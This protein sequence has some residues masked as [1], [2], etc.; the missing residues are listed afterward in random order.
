MKI[1]IFI[2]SFNDQKELAKIIT[3]LFDLNDTYTIYVVDDGSIP[4]IYLNLDKAF[5]FRIPFN[6]GIGAAMSIALHIS[7]SNNFDFMVRVD[8]DGQHP[9]QNVKKILDKMILEND[10]LCI[11]QRLNNES[12][13]T[14]RD[15][16]GTLVKKHINFLSN[17]ITGNQIND[18]STG[19]FAMNRFAIKEISQFDYARYPEV[20]LFL[21]AHHLG[22]KIS[23]FNIQQYNRIQGFSSIT[24]AQSLRLIIRFYLLLVRQILRK[25]I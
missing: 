8:A 18:W 15:I 3:E 21:N 24:F 5:L 19:F 9:T 17:L 23:T 6:A 25:I 11:G 1:L 13:D 7:K 12:L 16:L 20:E 14:F 4:P 2:P 22:L 10:D